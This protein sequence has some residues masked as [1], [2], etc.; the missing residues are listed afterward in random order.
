MNIKYPF[1]NTCIAK[2]D[3]FLIHSEILEIDFNKLTIRN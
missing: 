2:K 1:L 3:A